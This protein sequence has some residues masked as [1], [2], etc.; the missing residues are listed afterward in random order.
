MEKN[1][2]TKVNN[3]KTKVNKNLV[4]KNSKKSN[5]TVKK[6]TVKNNLLEDKNYK[7][8]EKYFKNKEYEKAYKEYLNLC[9]IYPKN[10]RLYKRLI[11]S[12]THNY[13]YKERT[14][15]FKAAL[16][17][18]II[19]YKILATKKEVK[20]FE[21]KLLEYKHVKVI[22]DKS[23]F[24][25]I[26]FL[27][28]LGVHKFID[29]KYIKGIFYFLTFGLFGIGVIIDLIN[30]Y[31]EYENDYQLDIF[32]YV[33]SCLILVFSL[34]RLNTTNYYYFI[35]IAIILTPIIY[36]KVLRIIPGLIKIISIII[37]CYFGF[38]IEPVVNYVPNFVIGKWSTENENTNFTS[39]KI[40]QDKSTIYF[41]DR[42]SETG[43]NTYDNTNKILT[44]TVNETNV[45]KF[46][47]D[48][49]NE[50]LCTYTDAKKCIIA[51][52]K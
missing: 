26:A 28:F 13:S 4:K 44:I 2:K 3:K 6:K 46:R 25:I 11:E 19:T 50:E 41:V 39:I 31:A 51:F 35:I 43:F 24:L 47:I 18:Y 20:F 40:K 42:D 9:D 45:Y 52:K 16:D 15:E 29:K 36:S 30:D 8:A 49:E 14:K 23:K 37:L 33:I 7:L 12:L 17:D 10:K 27:G 5:N 48:L 22:G 38:R 32:R 21:N 1:K 34:F